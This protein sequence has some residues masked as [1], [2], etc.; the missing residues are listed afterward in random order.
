MSQV[1]RFMTGPENQHQLRKPRVVNNFDAYEN[2]QKC[3]LNSYCRTLHPTKDMN[4]QL[5]EL[6]FQVKGES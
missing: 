5:V 1:P 2:I 4:D 3:F 6:D